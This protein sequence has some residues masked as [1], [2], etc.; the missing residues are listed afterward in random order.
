MLRAD[1]SHASQ[2]RIRAR[3]MVKRWVAW[4][5][6]NRELAEIW[7]RGGMWIRLRVN[8]RQLLSMFVILR[9]VLTGGYFIF[10]VC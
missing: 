9:Y 5:R 10:A 3:R 8:S 2:V 7:V 6:K 4:S 1:A